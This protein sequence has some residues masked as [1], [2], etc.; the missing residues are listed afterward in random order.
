MLA[1]MHA[2][3]AVL[4]L[5]CL[6]RLLQSQEFITQWTE[7]EQ[8]LRQIPDPVRFGRDMT[9]EMVQTL[10]DEQKEQ[11]QKLK[12][13]AEAFRDSLAQVQLNSSAS[14]SS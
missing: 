1:E 11:L 7:Y 2:K 6:R 3:H 5:A 8:M 14:S 4:P 10:S 13:E 9:G 12:E